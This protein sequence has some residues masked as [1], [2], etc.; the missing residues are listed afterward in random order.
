MVFIGDIIYSLFKNRQ[1]IQ[2]AQNSKGN[3]T[4]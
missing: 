2:M 3:M 1:Y 4:K